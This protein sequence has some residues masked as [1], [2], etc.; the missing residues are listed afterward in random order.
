GRVLRSDIATHSAVDKHR[1]ETLT[2]IPEITYEYTV[3]GRKYVGQ[4]ISFNKF[5]NVRFNKMRN[6]ADSYPK[7]AIIPVYYHPI[8]PHKAVLN[9]EL[10]TTVLL[11]RVG[12]A[13]FLAALGY[14]VMVGFFE[15]F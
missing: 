15:Q 11:Q 5:Q 8:R 14:G 7:G 10:N 9:R 12:M 6:I 4:R 2:Y 1:N 13:L 3:D